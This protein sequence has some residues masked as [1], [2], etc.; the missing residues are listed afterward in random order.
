MMDRSASLKISCFS[1]GR[2][3]N[4]LRIAKDPL[5][6]Y[7]H[8]VGKALQSQQ[9]LQEGSVYALYRPI[10]HMTVTEW[11]CERVIFSAPA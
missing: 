7:Q 5:N 10:V 9:P 1:P 3:I 4:N 11:I 2:P 6:F 8:W